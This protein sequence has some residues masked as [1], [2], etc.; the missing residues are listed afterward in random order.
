MGDIPGTANMG[1]S[2][3]SSTTH[4]YA[5]S[6]GAQVSNQICKYSFTTDGNSTDVGD[7]TVARA[8]V[9]GTHV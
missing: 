3:H 5:T 9:G 1:N 4:G 6:V 8:Y 2:G 7:L